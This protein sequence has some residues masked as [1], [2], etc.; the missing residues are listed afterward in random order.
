MKRHSHISIVEYQPDDWPEVDAFWNVIHGKAWNDLTRK[1]WHWLNRM[2]THFIVKKGKQ[3]LGNATLLRQKFAGNDG[4]PFE[5]GWITDFFVIPDFKRQGL[6]KRLTSRLEKETDITA[7]FG[8]SEASRQCFTRLG[9]TAPSFIQI[10]GFTFPWFQRYPSGEISMEQVNFRDPVF[11]WIWENRDQSVVS[12]GVRDA[13]T[14]GER[15]EERPDG[16]YEAWIARKHDKAFGYIVLRMIRGRYN[17]MFGW[18]PVG[19]FVD[20]F[21][22]GNEPAILNAMI[23]F[24]LCRLGQKGAIFVL[25]IDTIGRVGKILRKTGFYPDLRVGWLKFRPLPAKGFMMKIRGDC[26]F[27]AVPY[28]TFMDCDAELTF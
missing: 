11:D 3:V 22:I 9:W 6:G 25:A 18:L 14:I 13:K 8:Q 23:Q 17:K 27:T 12:I 24:G 21:S 28:L 10:L 15:F 5:L 26:Q 2:R 19:L 4:V 20:L 7:T 1:R 16:R